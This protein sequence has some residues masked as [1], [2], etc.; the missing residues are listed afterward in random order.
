LTLRNPR[1]Y[2]GYYGRSK[3]TP[4]TKI[5]TKKEG[6]KSRDRMKTIKVSDYIVKYLSAQGVT[7]IFEL[8]G[9]MITHLLD[10]L[11][12]NGSIS[13]ISMH[14]EQSAAFAVD[15]IGRIAHRP[16]VALATSG[17]GATNL[18]TGIGSCYFDSSPGVFITGQVNRYEQKGDR[19]IRQLGFQECDI[20]SMAQAVTKGAWAVRT[21]EEVPELLQRAFTVATQGR[22]GPVLLDIPMDIQRE[23]IEDLPITVKSVEPPTRLCDNQVIEDLFDAIICAQR[24]LII[25]G[26]GVQAS[27][28]TNL[29]RDFAQKTRIPVAH[30]LMAVDTLPCDDPLRV[31][32]IGSYG[33]RW[34]N[35]AVGLSDLIL[36]LGSRLDI[37]QTGADVQSWKG[38][39]AVFHIDC[40]PDEINN[41]VMGCRAIVGDLGA[42]LTNALA[43]AD[44]HTF[45]QRQEWL[46]EIRTL[47][48]K[49][50]D[51]AELSGCEGINPN[52]FMHELSAASEQ[53]GTYVI[54]VG[55]NQMWAAQSLEISASQRFLTSGG[56]GAMGFALPG[57]IGATLATDKPVVVVAGDGGF[58]VN[59]QELETVVRNQ[60]PLKIV[61]LDNRCLGMVRQFQECYFDSQYRSTILGYGAPDFVRVTEA[62]GISARKVSTPDETASS[63]EWLWEDPLK[64]ALLQVVLSPYTNVY[65]KI[66]FGAPMTQME[67]LSSV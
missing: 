25:A 27:D 61:V 63:L 11:H 19:P 40:E 13:V 38:N 22:P 57:A 24:P 39:R 10:S 17:P 5:T 56:M 34:A 43:M 64:P 20:V 44:G 50:L 21:V 28:A 51:T 8:A 48:K 31:G 66:T 3:D 41:R 58:Q 54:D 53:A 60:L 32:M 30:S 4:D 15:V 47:K 62:Y 16:S 7:H 26:G 49:W 9:G 6:W 59:L 45:P 23:Q 12:H 36:V 29:F 35:L 42:F 33:N 55:Q 14:H 65:P 1:T 52:I 18:L 37:R 67:P 2:D 46:S